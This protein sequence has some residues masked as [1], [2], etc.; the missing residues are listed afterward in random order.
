LVHPPFQ[1]QKAKGEKFGGSAVGDTV[2]YLSLKA[3]GLLV[4]EEGSEFVTL[5]RKVE[6]SDKSVF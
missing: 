3:F 6:G 4:D 2:I 1:T 5:N